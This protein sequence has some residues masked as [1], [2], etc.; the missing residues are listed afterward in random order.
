MKWELHGMKPATVDRCRAYLLVISLATVLIQAIVLGMTFLFDAPETLFTSSVFRIGLV[1]LVATAVVL[2]RRLAE[3]AFRSA[4]AGDHIGFDEARC[5][6]VTLSSHC[7]QRAL[8]V[9]HVRFNRRQCVPLQAEPLQHAAAP[10]RG[11]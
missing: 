9:L 8:V 5:G 7:P 6:V 1:G 4:L 2:T 11:V 10:R 3:S